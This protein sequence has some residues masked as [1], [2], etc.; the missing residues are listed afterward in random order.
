M[1]KTLFPFSA[2]VGQHDY[3][4][5]LLLLAVDPHL[6]GV[7]VSGP[8]GT[9]KSTL[10]RGF[11][12]LLNLEQSSEASDA[13]PFV[14][15]PLGASEEMLVGTMDLEQVLQERTQR[16]RPGLLA[17]AHQGVLYVDEVNLLPDTLVD[18]LLDVS[19]SGTISRKATMPTVT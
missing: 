17:Q 11:S 15:L 3:K 10:A 4:L 1:T 2:V 6:G 9:A 14:N 13:A 5:A 12:E 16:F 18:V 19:A 7:V 8:R